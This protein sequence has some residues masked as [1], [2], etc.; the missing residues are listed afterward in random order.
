MPPNNFVLPTRKKGGHFL[1]LLDHSS[2]RAWQAPVT[3]PGG[4]NT[5]FFITTK[6]AA[7]PGATTLAAFAAALGSE[8][9]A[10]RVGLP[11]ALADDPVTNER[12]LHFTRNFWDRGDRSTPGVRYRSTES[13][14]HPV[15]RD[16]VKMGPSIGPPISGLAIFRAMSPCRHF[17]CPRGHDS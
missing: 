3:Q 17:P 7:V 10:R 5:P 9:K 13:I 11:C 16:R 15:F 14:K 4:P 1:T 12:E 2:G 6:G 8:A